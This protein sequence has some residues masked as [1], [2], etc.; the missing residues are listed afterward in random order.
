MQCSF[1]E[2]LVI[3]ATG[4]NGT[5]YSRKIIGNSAT[6]IT[7]ISGNITPTNGNSRYYIQD[8]EAFGD[9]ESYLA[10]NQSSY[11]LATSATISTLVDTTK[12]W[13]LGGLLSQWTGVKVLITDPS[14]ATMETVITSNNATTLNIGR[15]VAVG[16]GTVNTIAYSDDNGVTWVGLGASIFSTSGNAVCWSGSRFLAV[17]AGTN[18][19]A[20][21]NDGVTWVGVG[22]LFGTAGNGICW[23][24]TRFV[25]VGSG[26]NGIIYSYDG[27][28]WTSSTSL[29]LFTSQVNSLE[30]RRVLPWTGTTSNHFQA[31]PTGPI[32][33]GAV[34]DYFITTTKNNVYAYAGT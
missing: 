30:S 25:G 22:I 17:G 1:V 16:T 8:L 18:T 7:T 20:W 5:G 9:A 6:T 29:N 11:G 34:G 31:G 19:V 12:N 21:S 32:G 2:Y 15:T 27:N 28:T 23:N 14:G 33:P 13:T 4:I 10:D 26:T 3:Q 24:G